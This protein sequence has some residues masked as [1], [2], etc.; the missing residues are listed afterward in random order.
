MRRPAPT[1]SAPSP[2]RPESHQVFQDEVL[3]V[4]A[5]G[6]AVALTTALVV[7]PLCMRLAR[8]CGVVDKPGGRKTHEKV[9]PLMGG[10]GVVIAAAAG[11]AV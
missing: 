8:K 10:V 11:F 3:R 2:T 4:A 5:Q 1:R 9:T 7:M 6:F